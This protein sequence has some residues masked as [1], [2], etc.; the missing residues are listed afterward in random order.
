[1]KVQSPDKGSQEFCPSYQFVGQ[2][3]QRQ[4]FGKAYRAVSCAE[5]L[6]LPFG[7]FNEMKRG[8]EPSPGH[9]GAS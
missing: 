6:S 1:L 7:D 5:D 9:A 3:T 8:K 4:I 2:G